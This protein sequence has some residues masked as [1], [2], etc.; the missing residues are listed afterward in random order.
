MHQFHHLFL[1]QQA[2]PDNLP[3]KPNLNLSFASRFQTVR[4]LSSNMGNSILDVNA[5]GDVYSGRRNCH[6]RAGGTLKSISNLTRGA[7]GSQQETVFSSV[8][9]E[10]QLWTLFV[11][12]NWFSLHD[13]IHGEQNHRRT[14]QL[15]PKLISL[16]KRKGDLG[17]LEASIFTFDGFVNWLNVTQFMK[18]RLEWEF[19]YYVCISIIQEVDNPYQS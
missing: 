10:E 1:L 14:C 17:Q 12:M 5:V 11:D 2:N 7:G 19:Y 6:R 18:K 16:N 15:S 4:Q 13:V 8:N 9:F 3:S